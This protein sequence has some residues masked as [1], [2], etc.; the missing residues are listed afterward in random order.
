MEHKEITYEVCGYDLDYDVYTT[1]YKTT[2]KDKAYEIAR[3]F[4]DNLD[5]LV[6]YH[7][8]ERSRKLNK[9][10]V[11]WIEIWKGWPDAEER[12]EIIYGPDDWR[13]KERNKI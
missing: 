2:D 8:D 4:A 12:I 11:D 13:N 7:D 9:E 3:I 6:T 5:Y 10:P 1:Y